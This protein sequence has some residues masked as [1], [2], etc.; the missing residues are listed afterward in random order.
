MFDTTEIVATRILAWRAAIASGTDD[1]PTSDTPNEASIRISAL[2]SYDG[3]RIA[4]YTPRPLHNGVMASN[5]AS[6]YASSSGTNRG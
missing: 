1:I 4:A 5:I 3:P 2:V 6:S